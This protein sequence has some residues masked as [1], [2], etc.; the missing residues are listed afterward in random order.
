[1]GIRA[2]GM[3]VSNSEEGGE[4]VKDDIQGGTAET[5]GHFQSCMEIQYSRSF[6]KFVN[7]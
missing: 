6:L 7:I 4:E 1:M 5:K 3:D 2:T